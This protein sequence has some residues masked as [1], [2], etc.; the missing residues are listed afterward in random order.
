[1]DLIDFFFFLL[2]QNAGAATTPERKNNNYNH[3]NNK[4]ERKFSHGDESVSPAA[5]PSRKWK[6][7]RVR[8]SPAE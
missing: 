4:K 7:I 8:K 3:Y 5:R 6:Q 1:M 2:R